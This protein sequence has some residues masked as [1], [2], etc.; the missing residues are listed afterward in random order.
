MRRNEITINDSIKVVKK[1]ECNQL[2]SNHPIEDRLRV[3]KL[4]LSPSSGQ[5][6]SMLVGVFDGH[7]GLSFAEVVSHRLFNYIALSLS[8][9]PRSI[10]A[11][12]QFADTIIDLYSCPNPKQ[13]KATLYDDKA[14]VTI[15]SVVRASETDFLK[16]YADKLVDK[17]LA[18]IAEK[19]S[20]A[21]QQCDSDLSEE[22]ER[23]LSP[24]TPN[25]L[26]HYYYSL[27][28]SGCCATVLLLHE[29]MVYIAN[30]GNTLAHS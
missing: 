6:E 13:N 12:N 24:G 30:S 17:P 5:A 16:K 21:F 23:S 22:I 4:N 20:D 28:A 18:T 2:A 27:A 3:S 26:L 7:G 9:D 10:L 1:I 19:L 25:L 8:S 15:R 11:N 14:F 29:N